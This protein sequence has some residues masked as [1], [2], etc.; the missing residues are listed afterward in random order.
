MNSVLITGCSSGFGLETA[1]YF[2]SQGWL[3]IATMRKP[4]PSILP[5]SENLRILPLD[6][7]SPD[8]IKSVVSDAGQIDVLVNNAGIGYMSPFENT[9]K[10][11]VRRL[12][13][14]NSFGMFEMTRAVVPQ[15]RERGTGTIINLSSSTT[16]KPLTFMSV[17]T[18][19]KAAVNAFTECLALE[20]APLGIRTRLVIPGLSP[21][22]SF[23]D[24]ARSQIASSGEPPAEYKPILQQ[25]MGAFQKEIDTQ[26]LTKPEDVVQAIW[27]AA[28]DPDCPVR[29]PAGADAIALSR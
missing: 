16:L 13:E 19:S 6:V 4:D 15:M 23:G 29:L 20:L 1:K 21:S 8:S 28:T 11:T 3:V 9:S 25:V 10:E 18:A 5:A 26:E 7:T 27:R 22:T 14:T 17:Y 24:S 12:F 2:L